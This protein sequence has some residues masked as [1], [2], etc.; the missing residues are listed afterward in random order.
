MNYNFSETSL[1]TSL[2]I[3]KLIVR[4]F[5]NKSVM[6]INDGQY[7]LLLFKIYLFYHHKQ[8]LSKKVYKKK[9]IVQMTSYNSEFHI[10]V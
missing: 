2:Q 1:T 7:L 5:K 4:A 3:K 10:R 8:W 6:S 9:E